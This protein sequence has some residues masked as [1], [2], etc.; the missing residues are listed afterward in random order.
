MQIH[1]SIGHAV[2]L[3][4]VLGRETSYAGGSFV[5]ADAVGSLRIG[6]AS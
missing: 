3:D 1:E 2:E 5:A 4:R 6:S